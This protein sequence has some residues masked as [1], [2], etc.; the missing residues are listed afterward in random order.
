MWPPLT[1]GQAAVCRAQH[2]LWT[3]KLFTEAGFQLFLP[4]GQTD[5][6]QGLKMCLS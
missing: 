1:P 5:I 6:S 2:I 4:V 3:P